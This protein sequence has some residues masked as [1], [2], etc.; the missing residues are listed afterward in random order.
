MAGMGLAPRRT[1]VAENIRNLKSRTRHAGP[2]STRRPGL[3]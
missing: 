1:T 3:L 2:A